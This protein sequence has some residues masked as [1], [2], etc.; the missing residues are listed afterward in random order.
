MKPAYV[1]APLIL[2]ILTGLGAVVWLAPQSGDPAPDI[3]MTTL[4]GERFN[5]LDLRGRPVLVTFWATNC[6]TCLAEMPHLAELHEEFGGQGLKVIGV[7][8]HYDPE[9]RVRELVAQRGLPYRIVM[10]EDQ[11]IQRAFGEVRVTPTNYLIS[12]RGR[13]VEREIG[14]LNRAALRDRLERML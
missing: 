12:P 6:P 9:H 1:V 3:A 14:E 2:L 13:I 5:L 10:D 11:D 8:M 7:A 4:E